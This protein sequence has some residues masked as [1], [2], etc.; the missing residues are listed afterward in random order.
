MKVH[1]TASPPRRDPRTKTLY[2]GYPYCG[3]A[4]GPDS[5][6]VRTP[7]KV[8]CANCAKAFGPKTRKAITN[9]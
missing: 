6:L 4:A 5:K 8:T 9:A 1:Y 7:A 3:T 2:K